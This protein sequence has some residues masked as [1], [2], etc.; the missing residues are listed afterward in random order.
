MAIA[1]KTAAPT[2]YGT[3]RRKTAVAR[4]FMKKGTGVIVVN[5]KPLEQ[6]LPRKSDQVISCQ[7][8]TLLDLLTS[9]DFFLTTSGGGTTG[10]AGAIRLAISR[11]LV[12][13]DE[14]GKGPDVEN[15]TSYRRKLRAAGF[16]TRDARE[17]ERKKVGLHGARKRPQYSKR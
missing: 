10:Q 11:A 14:D 7:P 2:N 1:K 13:F 6:V 9:F 12:D 8:L 4:A 16:L 3:G 17:V 5:G 15:L